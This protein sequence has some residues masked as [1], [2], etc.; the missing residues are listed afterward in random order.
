MGGCE[1][2]QEGEGEEGVVSSSATVEK[3]YRRE[4]KI[5]IKPLCFVG[6]MLLLLLLLLLLERFRI[7]DLPAFAGAW[8]QGQEV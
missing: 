6:W 4:P 5:F 1:G 2:E 3:L 8:W 7:L